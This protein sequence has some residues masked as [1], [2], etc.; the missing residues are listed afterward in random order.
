MNI[1]MTYRDVI[2]YTDLQVY[3]ISVLGYD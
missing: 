3:L 2:T 1:N